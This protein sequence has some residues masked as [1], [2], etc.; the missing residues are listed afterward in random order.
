M[1]IW[2]S[3]KDYE[4]LYEVSNLGRVKSLGNNKER[5]EK[6]L[7]HGVDKTG[8]YRVGLSKNNIAKT[9][10]VHQLVAMAFLNHIPCGHKIV[11]DHINDDPLDN[12]VDN[13]QVVTQRFNA[14]KTQGKYTSKY[15]GVCW[16]KTFN[17]WVSKITINSKNYHLG[18]FKCELAAHQSYQNKLK[19]II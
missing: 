9:H 6:F 14:C 17:K 2:K 19:E 8:Y 18:Y 4:G 11:V 3:I 16:H 1:E 12:R 15:K 5:K 7:K 13:L 10:K